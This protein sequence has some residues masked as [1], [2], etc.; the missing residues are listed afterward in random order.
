MPGASPPARA[1][2]LVVRLVVGLAALS[3]VLSGLAAVALD[4]ALGQVTLEA[5]RSVLDAQVIALVASAERSGPGLLVAPSPA[6]ARLSTPGSGLFAEIRNSAGTVTW[7]SPSSVG[8]G[9]DLATRPAPGERVIEELVLPDGTRTLALSLGVRW[10]TASGRGEEYVLSAAESLEP[11]YGQ[12]AR[13]R[14]WLAGGAIA[15]MALLAGALGLGLRAGL[16][17]LRRIERQIAEIE[18]GRREQLE[19]RWPRELQGVTGNLNA[20]LAGERSRLGR[21]RDTLGNLAHSLK[22]PLAAMHAF[23]ADG[24]EGAR[25]ALE[26]QLARMREIVD[27]QL[28]RAVLAGAGMTLAATPVR[29]LL[30]ELAGALGKVYRDRQVAAT[31]DAPPEVAYPIERGD[32]FELAGNLA[33][34]A[35]KYCRARVTIR[36]RGWRQPQWR[37]DGLVLDFEDDGGGIPEADRARVLE[38]GVRV[39]E[40]RSGQGIGLAAA[41]EIAAAYGGTLEIGDSGL[42]GARVTARLPGR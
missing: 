20:L 2:S 37:R 30:E 21:Y 39:D 29:P 40:T 7:R 38:R 19:G 8:S 3:A 13:L 31:L 22:T 34:N 23:L 15:L 28:R 18:A 11:W 16:R 26:P 41:R 6:E 5:R 4:I 17:P 42:G 12:R 35:F 27:H 9:L 24:D 32:L 33:D 1:P 10:E 14:L 25:R 36:A